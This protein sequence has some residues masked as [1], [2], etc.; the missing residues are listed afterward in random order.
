MVDNST[1]VEQTAKQSSLDGIDVEMEVSATVL[2]KP[3]KPDDQDGNS[4]ST[5]SPTKKKAKKRKPKPVSP[6]LSQKKAKK[7]P[8]R[9]E[10]PKVGKCLTALNSVQWNQNQ[11][12]ILG[13]VRY[14][15]VRRD[16]LRK[17]FPD[18]HHLDVTKKIGEEWT[19]MEVDKK[20]PFLDAAKDD[21]TR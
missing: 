17:E 9:P 7:D 18:M 11:F 13:Y 21:K 5:S 4:A 19:T 12:G 20:K 8:N 15:N 14:M 6:S 16:E 3:D 1:A 2:S 10:Y